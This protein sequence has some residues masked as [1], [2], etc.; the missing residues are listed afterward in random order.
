[1]ATL[2]RA[3]AIAV[4]AHRGQIYRAAQPYIMHPL[5]LMLAVEG[6]GEEAMIVAVLHDVVEDTPWT[7]EQLAAEGFAPHLV[8]A[9]ELLTRQEDETY[10]AFIERIA[11][12]PL[13]RL[14]KLADLKDNMD[15]RRLPEFGK[16]D[17]ERM[18]RYHR[19]WKRLHG[20]G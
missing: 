4:E 14:V 13:A 16:K 9:I 11:P 19:A 8:A 18:E 3:I 2:E 7:I 6:E 20:D 15:V 5:R 12:D 1:M 10:E 17:A